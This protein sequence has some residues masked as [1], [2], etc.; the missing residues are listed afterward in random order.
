M[1]RNICLLKTQMQTFTYELHQ[2]MY[3]YKMRGKVEMK[4]LRLDILL[5]KKKVQLGVR[6]HTNIVLGLNEIKKNSMR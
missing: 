1:H 2:N 3:P 6:I 5:K 4:L